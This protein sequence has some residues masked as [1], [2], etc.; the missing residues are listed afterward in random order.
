M[1][2][3]N[4]GNRMLLLSCYVLS[5]CATG[6][7]GKDSLLA[8]PPAPMA[9]TSGQVSD[10]SLTPDSQ[11]NNQVSVFYA[12]RR[13]PTD[14]ETGYSK[15]FDDNLRA[16]KASLYIGSQNLG[17]DSLYAAAISAERD[18]R[19]DI[20]LKQTE[21]IA[22]MA[23]GDSA[24]ELSPDMRAY[25]AQIDAALEH[26]AYKDITIIVHGAFN[27]FYYAVAEAA[28]YRFY[29]GKQAVVIAYSW[30]AVENHL[31]YKAN[32]EHAEQ[33]EAALVKLV[34]VLGKH[35]SAQRINIIGYSVG[36]RLAGGAMAKLADE[37]AGKDLTRVN[38]DFRLG[39]LYL[40]S[41]DEPLEEF[42][43]YVSQFT[44]MF[45]LVTVT[46][47]FK[48]PILK[49]AQMT[50]GGK[51]LGRPSDPDHQ[52]AKNAATEEQRK[53]ILEA[54][55]SDQLHILNLGISEIPGYE[56]SHGAWYLNPW[57]SSDVLVALNMDL[58]P[59]QRG[60]ASSKEQA[61]TYWYFPKDYIS[62]L[63]QALLL[64][65][66]KREREEAKGN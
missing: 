48:D 45:D 13:L 11:K 59:G 63:R 34:K 35:S 28:Q 10:F 52:K 65:K 22:E 47:D 27:N 49:E 31:A 8:L 2:Y 24:T 50:G 32:A 9:V 6:A 58:S 46:I 43:N 44:A 37:F 30:P 20:H 64:H 54:V 21:Q 5:C 19:Y 61:L 25:V 26:S 12:T 3:S 41:S 14:D 16:G 17:W 23:P 53:N 60:L 66:S 40:T 62:K 29:A 39:H 38:K 1:I 15:A 4:F 55:N 33:S 57:V 36:G 7:Y 51:R 42:R 18:Q 56:F